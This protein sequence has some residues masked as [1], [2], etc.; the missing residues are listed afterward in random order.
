MDKSIYI[1]VITVDEDSIRK[2]TTNLGC[3]SQT[4]ERKVTKM[5]K[6]KIKDE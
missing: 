4:P 5:L 3:G 6:N 1:S 2:F